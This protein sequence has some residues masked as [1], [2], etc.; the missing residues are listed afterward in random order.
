MPSRPAQLRPVTKHEPNDDFTKAIGRPVRK[1]AGCKSLPAG[2]LN[3]DD[4]GIEH[5]SDSSD[6]EQE[7]LRKSWKQKAFPR[8]EPLSPTH[9]ADF[10]TPSRETSPEQH[11]SNCTTWKPVPESVSLTFNVPKDHNGP[12]VV[13][14]SLK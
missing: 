11:E 3:P 5:G 8:V 6:S 13:N 4:A 10:D 12:F 14:L 1:L 7:P 2:Y 9:P